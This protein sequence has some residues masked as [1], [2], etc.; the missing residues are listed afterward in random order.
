MDSILG[1]SLTHSKNL[2]LTVGTLLDT[3]NT[4]IKEKPNAL[5]N[6]VFMSSDEEGNQALHLY[7]IDITKSGQL[8]LW[9]A[10]GHDI[11]FP[12]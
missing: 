8:T 7:A 9:P 12:T 11:E 5:K 4:L 2:P 6:P 3:L 10:G 1:K